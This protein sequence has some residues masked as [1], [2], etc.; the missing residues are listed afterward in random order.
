MTKKQMI[1]KEEVMRLFNSKIK[2]RMRGLE[3]VRGE[4][5]QKLFFTYAV[6][7]TISVLI[8][9][10]VEDTDIQFVV[11]MAGVVCFGSQWV[12]MRKFIRK[13]KTEVVQEIFNVLVD[14][15]QYQQQGSVP[16]PLVDAS[17]LISNSYNKFS[18]EDYVRGELAGF[19]MQFSELDLRKVSGSGKNRRETTIFR[20]LFFHFSL[21]RNLGHRT[22]I[23]QD[24]GESFFGKQIGRLMQK[25]NARTGYELVLLESVEF[26]KMY[27]VYSDDQVKARVLL[28]PSVME[29]LT[30]FHRKY[31][32][33]VEISVQGADLYV[34]ISTN[35][36]HFEPKIFGEVVSLKEIREIYDLIFLIRNLQDELELERAS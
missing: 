24:V 19:Q 30:Q 14:N 10:Y 33:K 23:C 11:P 25:A 1:S 35:T 36:N 5:K 26:E 31:K 18:G 17:H 7:I 12:I 2:P 16:Q 15:C 9:K 21:A 6:V 27:S 22:L 28:R 4:A 8:L 32:Q 29:G 34:T 3:K 13:F 20:G